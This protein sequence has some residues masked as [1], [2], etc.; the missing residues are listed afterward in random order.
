MET[1]AERVMSLVERTDGEE[2]NVLKSLRSMLKS[3]VSSLPAAPIKLACAQTKF[4]LNVIQ[5]E[6]EGGRPTGRFRRNRWTDPTNPRFS[7]RSIGL[8][9]Y[10]K[11]IDTALTVSLA[12]VGGNACCTME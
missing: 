12:T 1:V 10:M 7:G 3:T 6:G 11:R 8:I 2:I 4:D 5:M 9:L